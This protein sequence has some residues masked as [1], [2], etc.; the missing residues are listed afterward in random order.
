[1][2]WV[3]DTKTKYNLSPLVAVGLVIAALL[4]FGAIAE[5]ASAEGRGRGHDKYDRHRNW[6]GGYYRAPPVIYG[7]PYGPSYYQRPYYGPPI[8]YAP[9]LVYGPGLQF[10]FQLR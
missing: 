3:V 10:N 1:M 6:N 8:Y 4:A 7:S 9:P 2:A 5:S